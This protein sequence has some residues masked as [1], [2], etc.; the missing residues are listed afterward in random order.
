MGVGLRLGLGLEWGGL[1]M[2][3]VCGMVL[4]MLGVML[5][6]IL[7]GMRVLPVL[8]GV[9]HLRRAMH[10]RLLLRVVLRVTLVARLRLLLLL[11]E[12]RAGMALWVRLL[13][14]RA[15]RGGVVRGGRRGG[16][17]ECALRVRRVLVRGIGR[18]RASTESFRASWLKKNK[19]R[20]ASHEFER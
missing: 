1:V 2:R 15:R 9:C 12:R 11:C 6:L 18:L 10:R 4:L 5:V 8:R 13:R 17:R 3:G 16:R 19:S 14:R 7:R 20:Q